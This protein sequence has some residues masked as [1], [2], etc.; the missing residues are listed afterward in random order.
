VGGYALMN[1]GMISTKIDRELRT[2]S[3]AISRH[4]SSLDFLNRN[5]VSQDM[6][7]NMRHFVEHTML[8]AMFG[9]ND[10]ENSYDNIKNA[11]H[12]TKTKG[13]L[14]FLYRFHCYLQISVSHYTPDLENSER[15]MLKY[16]EHLAKIKEYLKVKHSLDLLSN[17]DKFPLKIDPALAEY[18]VKIADTI[19]KQRTNNSDEIFI[20]RYYIKKKKSFVVN[21]KIFYEIT[22]ETIVSYGKNDRIIAFTH[23]DIPHY[24]AISMRFVRDS[25]EIIGKTMPILIIVK[26]DV[27]IRPCELRNFAKILGVNINISRSASEYRGLM[28]FLT[29]KGFNLV[30]LI[31]FPENDYLS[32]RRGIVPSTD[33]MHFFNALDRCRLI[34]GSAGKGSNILRYLLYNLHNKTISDQYEWNGRDNYWSRPIKLHLKHGAIPFDEMPFCSSPVGHNPKPTALF[35]SISPIGREHELLARFIGSNTQ[36][37]GQLYTP[38]QDIISLGDIKTIGTLINAYNEKL[39]QT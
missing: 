8:K 28:H 13:D 16:Y 12:F 10:V 1:I 18:Y 24:Y 31:D 33:A 36:D 21:Q 25:I 19:T 15:L 37:R 7:Q 38:A 32:V 22:F 29:S 11:I 3:D 27:S 6:L 34:C 2:I 35:E 5:V 39:S 30:E 9:T 20:D 26:W 23:M 17:L 14:I 4:I